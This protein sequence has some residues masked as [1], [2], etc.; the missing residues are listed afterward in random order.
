MQRMRNTRALSHAICHFPEL[1]TSHF[2]SRTFPPPGYD[3]GRFIPHPFVPSAG[4]S[5]QPQRGRIFQ[6]SG[7]RR[8]SAAVG[9]AGMGCR[10][11][12]AGQRHYLSGFFLSGIRETRTLHAKRRF[13]FLTI[14][15][16]LCSKSLLDAYLSCVREGISIRL[17]SALMS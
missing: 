16:A 5:L 2:S 8:M 9:R 6:P 14:S 15:P 4:R 13:R 7:M 3:R 11:E 12:G 17:R 10:A 1:R